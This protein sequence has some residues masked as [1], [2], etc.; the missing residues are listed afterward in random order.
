[1]QDPSR[2]PPK[3]FGR[4]RNRYLTDK[5][6]ELL[7]RRLDDYRLD[8]ASMLP[9]QTHLE[10]GFGDGEHLFLQ[11]KEYPHIYWIGAEPYLNGVAQLL[12]RLEDTPL[13][14]LALWPDDVWGLLPM[15]PS[16]SIDRV[17]LLFPDPWP[18]RKHFKRRL[19]QHDFIDQMA[20]LISSNGELFIVTDHGEYASWIVYQFTSHGF[21]SWQAQTPVDWL[22]PPKSWKE[23]RYQKKALAGSTS[24]YLH[25]LANKG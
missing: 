22:T 19:V 6:K 8:P 13:D 23:T 12:M 24:Y 10:I 9:I 16:H 17:Y 21:F 1:M 18:K 4:I 20:R 3:S 14:N 5:K 7:Y 15:L 25:F 11:A 2:P